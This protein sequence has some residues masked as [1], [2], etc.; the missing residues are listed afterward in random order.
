[1]GGLPHHSSRDKLPTIQTGESLI[2][3]VQTERPTSGQNPYQPWGAAE[4]VMY[5]RDREVLMAGPAGT[6]KSRAGLEKLNICASK[7]PGMRALMLRKTLRSIRQSAMVTYET[8][9][10]PAKS[11]VYFHGGDY[12]YRYPNGSV[13]VVGGLDKSSKVMSTEYDMAYVMEATEL[14]EGD[15]EDV[16]T[17]LRN[18]VM[19]YQQLIADCNPTAPTH[20]L[21]KRVDRGKT[22]MLESRHQDNPRLWDRKAPCGLCMSSDGTGPTGRVEIE[23]N[24][25]LC[26]SCLGS[27]LGWWTPQGVAYMEVLDALTGARRDRLR[28]G[29]WVQAEGVVYDNWDRKV[30][31]VPRFP[32]PF[33]WR[34]WRVID[35][36]YAHPFVCQ[37]WAED[38]DGMLILYRE[39]VGVGRLV[40]DWAEVIRKWSG[41]EQYAG[42]ITDHDAEGRATLE[43]HLKCYTIPA[44]K[45]VKTGIQRFTKRLRVRGNGKPG[46]IVFDDALMFRDQEMDY[47]K[48]PIGLAE[49]IDTYIY[50]RGADG[51][52]KKEE[53]VKEDDHSLD[54]GRYM[55]MMLDEQDGGQADDTLD[56]LEE[57]FNGGY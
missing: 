44:R 30:H 42:T 50:Q 3:G 11:P 21:K 28:D 7:Y 37:W 43:R 35:F 5:T 46:L 47:R 53:P 2:G 19:P 20:W 51:T 45:A 14:Y 36:G 56:R 10:L 16:T 54:T 55:V 4:R 22:T 27:L 26:P 1:M 13:I 6:G 49:E 34:R 41:A 25:S 29:R 17:R 38:P 24:S 23:G 48:K 32:L 18:G 9:V 15:L 31:M 8:K 12:E 39:V 52:I 57:I 40:E 33:T